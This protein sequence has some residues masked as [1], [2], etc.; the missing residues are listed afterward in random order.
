MHRPLEGIRILEWAIHYA[1]PGAT[2]ILRDMGA[3]V[4]KI[5]RPVTGDPFRHPNLG[6]LEIEGNTDILFGGT[7][8]GKKSITLDLAH[9]DGKK[10]AYELVSKADIFITNVRTSTINTMQMDYSTLAKINPMLIYAR[11]NAFGTRGPDADKGGFDQQGQARAGMM[12]IL[13]DSEPR[14][15]LGGIIDHSTAIM[16]SYQM[17][18][19][20]L[21]RERF[22]I[23]QEVDVSLLG[24]ASYLMYLSDL[25]FLFDDKYNENMKMNPLRHHYRCRDG[26]WLILRIKDSNWAQV[27]GLIGCSSPENDQKFNDMVDG[28]ANSPELL[29]TFRQAFSSKPR[30]E[31]LRLF[32]DRNLAI[33]PV[34]TREEAFNDPQMIENGYVVNFEHPDMGSSRIPGFP[35]HLSKGEITNTV[36]APKLGEDTD[37][38]L[39][40]MLSYSHEEIA[41]LKARGVI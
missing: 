26:K 9:A 17:V 36:G 34:N 11:V 8:R 33:A 7:N 30:G 16:A 13:G 25:A 19:A 18:L 31:W 5:E 39:H 27:C 23:G 24:T 10:I 3:E 41:A 40:D 12:F 35:I 1:G 32:Y 29:S 15:I 6:S 4:I 38:I 22:G 21:M 28:I 2:A 14:P 20:I 37:K